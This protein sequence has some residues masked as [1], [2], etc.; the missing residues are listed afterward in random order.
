MDRY[1]HQ[2]RFYRYRKALKC[3]VSSLEG[4]KL[5]SRQSFKNML[6]TLALTFLVLMATK[7]LGMWIIMQVALLIKTFLSTC[8]LNRNSVS[9]YCD[10]LL[11]ASFSLLQTTKWNVHPN[12][13]W[14]WKF[15]YFQTRKSNFNA[16]NII[17]NS[18]HIS[19]YLID[20]EHVSRYVDSSWT[21]TR[22]PS[23]ILY[24]AYELQF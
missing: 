5:S 19:M 22:G 1:R 8:N 18:L 12:Y 4:F 24:S 14:S 21:W 10:L 11:R 15:R 9:G 7:N 3:Q 13:L 23:N 2:R 6:P 17:C 16:A 20:I